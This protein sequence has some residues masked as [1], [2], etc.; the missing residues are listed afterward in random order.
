LQNG[1]KVPAVF[2]EL[3]SA[4]L[5]VQGLKFN[6]N[7]QTFAVYG[8]KDYSIFTAR[9]FKSTTYGTGSEL[10]WS[11]SEI[12][13]VNAENAIKIIKGSQ[14]LSSFKLNFPFENIFGGDYL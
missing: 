10:V 8:E 7:G 13:A 2:K 5:Y 3:G 9:G 14:E 6:P 4:D 12:Y 11:K 1:D